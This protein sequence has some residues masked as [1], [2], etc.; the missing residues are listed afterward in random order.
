MFRHA[1]N[2]DQDVSSWDVSSVTDMTLMFHNASSFNQNLC[3]WGEHL[4]P[5]LVIADDGYCGKMFEGTSCPNETNPDLTTKGP[6]R[7]VCS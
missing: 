5:S 7:F 1:R 3:S 4:N 2:F 6:L